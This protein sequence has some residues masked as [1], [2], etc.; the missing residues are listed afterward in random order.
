M[1][2]AHYIL[3]A[4]LATV[5]SCQEYADTEDF[6]N[7]ASLPVSIEASISDS[8]TR[9]LL[10]ASGN[11]VFQNNDKVGIFMNSETFTCW[12]LGS[13]W[14]CASSLCWNDKTTSHLFEGFYPYQ[15]AKKDDE[16]PVPELWS[17]TGSLSSLSEHDFLTATN[18]LVYN[19]VNGVVSFTGTHAFTHKLTLLAITLPATDELQNSVI[20]SLK[21]TSKGLVCDQTYS[22]EEDAFTPVSTSKNPTHV[23]TSAPNVTVSAEQTLYYILNPVKEAINVSITYTKNEKQYSLTGALPQVETKAGSKYTTSI[24][25]NNNTLTVGTLSVGS[26]TNGG[27]LGSNSFSST[28]VTTQKEK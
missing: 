10:D 20:D 27:S 28:E 25:V 5:S 14:T 6:N 19:D 21:L 18:Q 9:T 11:T 15:S 12:T 4:A 3:T 17:Q 22:F 8:F 13:S 16:V 7:E 1:K 2:K 24:T 23:M 26:W